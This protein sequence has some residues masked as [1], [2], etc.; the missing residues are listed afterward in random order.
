MDDVD[1]LTKAGW[2]DNGDGTWSNARDFEYRDTDGRLVVRSVS[3]RVRGAVLIRINPRV[4]GYRPAAATGTGT[5]RG[6]A[7]PGKSAVRLTSR[8]CRGRRRGRCRCLKGDG[9]EPPRRAG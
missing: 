6:E 9:G 8:S 1:L 2:K 5:E 4:A 3:T 7:V